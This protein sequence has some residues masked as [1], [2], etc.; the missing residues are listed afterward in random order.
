MFS[1]WFIMRN[2]VF[3][4]ASRRVIHVWV[5]QFVFVFLSQRIGSCMIWQIWKCQFPQENLFSFHNFLFHHFIWYARIAVDEG[6]LSEWGHFYWQPEHGI[7]WLW[8]PSIRIF[9]HNNSHLL[10]SSRERRYCSFFFTRS[11]QISNTKI[12]F[13]QVFAAL[14]IIFPN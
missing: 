9:S 2:N 12:L 11:S 1:I 3:W 10:R 13:R 5:L 8:N 4:L 6:Y 7:Q 14:Y